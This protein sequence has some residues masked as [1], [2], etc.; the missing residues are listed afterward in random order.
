MTHF[1]SITASAGRVRP[2]GHNVPPRGRFHK[3]VDISKPWPPDLVTE[4]KHIHEYVATYLLTPLD[5]TRGERS[6]RRTFG[7]CEL[8]TYG[9]RTNEN[10]HPLRF[11][12]A[13]SVRSGLVGSPFTFDG[14]CLDSSLTDPSATCPALKYEIPKAYPE[15]SISTVTHATHGRIFSAIS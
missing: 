13:I 7:M 10:M 3:Y 2:T 6:P 8:L 1:E 12:D 11:L 15:G 4:D 5:V 14:L 9:V